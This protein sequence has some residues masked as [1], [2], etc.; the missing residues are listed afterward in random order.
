MSS[1]EEEWTF[2]AKEENKFL[3]GGKY[4]AQSGYLEEFGLAT[5][6]YVKGRR[7]AESEK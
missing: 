6:C 1:R 5:A 7:R 3:G 4:K 2:R